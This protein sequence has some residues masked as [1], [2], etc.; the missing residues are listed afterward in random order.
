MRSSAFA[1]AVLL[2]AAGVFGLWAQAGSAG[3]GSPQEAAVPSLAATYQRFFRIGA[4]A[5]PQALVLQGDLLAA[6]V[7]SL[8]AENGMK[9]ERIHPRAGDDASAYNFYSADQVVAFAKKNTMAV[10]GHTL[11]WHQQT[12]PWV[13]RGASGAATRDE[14]F[15]RMQG[16]ITTLLNRYKG[17]VYA[18]DVVNE[19]ISDSGEW[20]TDSP[21]YKAAGDDQDNDGI[22][23][24]IEKAF[25]FARA[26]DP[27]A[28][29]FYNDYNIESGAKLDKAYDLV[30]AL[31]EKGLVD[32]VGIQGHW[33]IYDVQ[34]ELIRRAI[35]R[36][37]SL[38]VEVQITELDLSVYRWGDNSKLTELPA[39]R[40][41]RQAQSYKA[42]FAMLRDEARSTGKLTGVTFWGIADDYTWLDNFPVAGRKNWP[43]LFDTSQKPKTAFWD[44]VKW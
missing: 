20:R 34:P 37:A 25:E 8:T 40:A 42:L 39:D 1:L 22:P 27:S 4:A 44:V 5:D 29:L 35:E 19:A 32:G 21:W 31:K 15:T 2:L 12:P 26:A 7:N 10:R 14:A 38:G 28:R 43:F 33:S 36:F 6:Q 23:D 9:W 24:Y 11:V 30:K 18:W 13:F 41:Q 3:S 16:H 17:S